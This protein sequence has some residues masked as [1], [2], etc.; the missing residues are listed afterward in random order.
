[1]EEDKQEETPKTNKFEFLNYIGYAVVIGAVAYGVFFFL[2]SQDTDTFTAQ[3]PVAVSDQIVQDSE[4]VDEKAVTE[5]V[6]EDL[7][8]GTGAEAVAGKSVTVH[9]A[10]TLTDGTKFDSSV[11]RNEPFVFNLGAGQVI[12]GWDQGFNGMK[13]GG[14]RK[15]T[16]PASL[17]YGDAGAPPV[18]PGGATLI[19]E[20]ELLEVN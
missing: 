2:S 20:V 10:G 8:V 15:L 5:L 3:N 16:I 11:D 4:M 12:A 7:E 9:Y 6:I 13:V 18:I 19:F 17:G 1:M 14:K